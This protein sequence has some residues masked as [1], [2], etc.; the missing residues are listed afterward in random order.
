MLDSDYKISAW[1]W[2]N[3]TDVGQREPTVHEIRCHVEVDNSPTEA[4]PNFFFSFKKFQDTFEKEPPP[5]YEALNVVTIFYNS[6]K[7]KNSHSS[8]TQTCVHN[9]FL[10]VFV[11]TV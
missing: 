7:S 10:W 5:S 3:R 11:N 6:V 8:D 2:P 9:H 4:C 1:W